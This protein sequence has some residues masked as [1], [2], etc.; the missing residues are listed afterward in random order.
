M[1]NGSPCVPERA[2]FVRCKARHGFTLIELLTVIVLFALLITFGVPSWV[3]WLQ[4]SQV[5]TAAE[6]ISNGLQLARADAVRRNTRVIFQLT[7]TATSGTSEW[8]VAANVDTA[9][10]DF[11]VAVQTRSSADTP[12]ARIGVSTAMQ[13]DPA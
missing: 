1:L 4:N 8:G 7:G 12:N 6:S 3:D 9:N 2:T 10:A 13:P 11:E 5:R